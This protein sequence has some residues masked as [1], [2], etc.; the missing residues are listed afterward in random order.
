MIRRSRLGPSIIDVCKQEGG[1]RQSSNEKVGT[2][3]LKC[4]DIGR[5]A[6]VGEAGAQK[7]KI[8]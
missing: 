4:A 5:G 7:V 3:V 2:H 6:N 1:K 8:L